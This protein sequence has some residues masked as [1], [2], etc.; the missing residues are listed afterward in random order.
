[1]PGDIIQIINNKVL[2]NNKTFKENAN[3]EF[4]YLVRTNGKSLSQKFIKD[5]EIHDGG[6]IN[7]SGDYCFAL[8]NKKAALLKKDEAI[9]SIEVFVEP[10]RKLNDEL[11]PHS[12]NNNWSLSNYGP[13]LVPKKGQTMKLD[14]ENVYYYSKLIFDH[15]NNK[16]EIRND[17]I[18]INDTY[19]TTYTFKMNYYFVLG[20]NRHNSIDSRYWGFVPE[21]HIIGKAT[22]IWFSIDKQKS[23][24]NKIRWSRMFKRI[25]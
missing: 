16:L 25:G 18:F 12:Y 6:M 17:S 9:E 8:T 21:D 3:V 19:T 1:M 20:D 13:L 7:E 23:F 22:M 11:F 2:V 5:N 15:E 4:N 10:K 24:F 14:M